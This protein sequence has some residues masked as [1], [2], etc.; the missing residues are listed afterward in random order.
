MS[1][2]KLKVY[3]PLLGIVVAIT[4]GVQAASSAPPRHKV[5]TRGQ[6]E[7]D[8]AAASRFCPGGTLSARLRR[9]DRGPDVVVFVRLPAASDRLQVH[10]LAWAA[11]YDVQLWVNCNALALQRFAFDACECCSLFG[12]RE[13]KFKLSSCTERLPH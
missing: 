13:N 2:V 9:R 12:H 1:R 5:T 3:Q 11:R 8:V 6:L 10:G 4:I 7:L